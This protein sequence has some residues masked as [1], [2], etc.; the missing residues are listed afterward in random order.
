MSCFSS[1]GG[2]DATPTAEPDRRPGDLRL[3]FRG[4]SGNQPAKS[5]A[6]SRLPAPSRGSGGKARREMDALPTGHAEG[7]RG[8]RDSARNPEAPAVKTGDAAR[9]L[10]VG[11]GLLRA[12]KVRCA[13]E[14]AAAGGIPNEVSGW[15]FRA[16]GSSGSER[17]NR[18]SC[19]LQSK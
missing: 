17:R 4:D 14:R 3:L 11:F 7:R 2:P 8:G 16:C 5:V 13:R 19:Q 9:Y 1:V 6:P 18:P 10:A 12:G 15:T